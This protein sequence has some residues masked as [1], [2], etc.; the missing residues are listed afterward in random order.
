[1]IRGAKPLTFQ[2]PVWT[3]PKYKRDADYPEI[4]SFSALS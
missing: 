1:M 2:N 4:L 3:D